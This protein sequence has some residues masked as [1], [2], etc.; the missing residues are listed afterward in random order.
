MYRNFSLSVGETVW[1]VITLRISLNLNDY[2]RAR[3][4]QVSSLLPAGPWRLAQRRRRL[5]RTVRETPERSGNR[6]FRVRTPYSSCDQAIEKITG[7]RPLDYFHLVWT[8][9]ATGRR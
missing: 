8:Q 7:E 4:A 1:E 3:L 9:E 6:P 2:E 5:Q